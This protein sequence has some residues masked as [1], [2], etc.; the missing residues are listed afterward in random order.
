MTGTWHMFFTK[1]TDSG[2]LS[3]KKCVLQRNVFF[4]R[5]P[6][7][8]H[9]S[10]FWG[11]PQDNVN[12]WKGVL[13]SHN[14]SQKSE[15]QKMYNAQKKWWKGMGEVSLCFITFVSDPFTLCL[16]FICFY[17]FSSFISSCLQ[18][19]FFLLCVKKKFGFLKFCLE[20][21]EKSLLCKLFWYWPGKPC[22]DREY[23]WRFEGLSG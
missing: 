5:E 2:F 18:L 22:R 19:D 8:N 9:C 23:G 4:L 3:L 16:V 1:K 14:F 17:N 20:K 6:K 12:K 15:N 11:I 21:G 13:S 10:F 7:K